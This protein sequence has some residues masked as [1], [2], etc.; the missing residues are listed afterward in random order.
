[1]SN[2]AAIAM[3]IV[4]M[5]VVFFVITISMMTWS[6]NGIYKVCIEAKA[7]GYKLE[8]CGDGNG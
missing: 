5:S 4:F 3:A 1:M 8:Q 7:K 6:S 2:E